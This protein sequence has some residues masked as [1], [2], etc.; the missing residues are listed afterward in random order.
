MQGLLLHLLLSYNKHAL[1][2]DNSLVSNAI[3]YDFYKETKT[4]F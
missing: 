3:N 4:E 1:I 2:Y